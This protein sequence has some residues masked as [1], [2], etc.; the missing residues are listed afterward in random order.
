[1]SRSLKGRP[2]RLPLEHGNSLRVAS[3][4]LRDQDYSAV[5]RIAD[6]RK[7]SISDVVREAIEYYLQSRQGSPPRHA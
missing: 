6:G 1:M 4:K 3:A 5:K 2:G 7:S